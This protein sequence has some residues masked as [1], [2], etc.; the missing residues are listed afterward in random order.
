MVSEIR[1][2]GFLF[3]SLILDHVMNSAKLVFCTLARF[4]LVQFAAQLSFLPVLLHILLL[5][6]L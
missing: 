1:P 2:S 5:H 6:G 3:S 4:F